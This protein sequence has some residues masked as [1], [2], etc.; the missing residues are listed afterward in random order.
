MRILDVTCGT[1]SIWYQ[2]N[3]PFVTY[4]DQRSET[5]NTL[6]NGNRL[7]CRRTLRIKP[8]ILAQWQHL[9]FKDAIFDLVVW[10]PPHI[11]R[12]DNQKNSILKMKYGVLN[13]ET[14]RQDLRL[15]AAEIFRV[16][17]P[18]GVLCFK[19]AET[20]ITLNQVFPLFPYKP[21]FGTRTNHG[22]RG[23]SSGSY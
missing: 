8:D 7:K 22:K 15:G 6:Q 19:W 9:P 23:G 3:L 16:L 20:D 14:W 1:K 17:R 21:L 11:I 4:L 12:K 2:K 5:I 13:K 10:D 18:D